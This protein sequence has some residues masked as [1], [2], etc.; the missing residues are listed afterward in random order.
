VRFDFVAGYYVP[1]HT[2]G[3]WRRFECNYRKANDTRIQNVSFFLNAHQRSTITISKGA[4]ALRCI[5]TTTPSS[6]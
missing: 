6:K 3:H 4:A 1:G 5:P 2:A